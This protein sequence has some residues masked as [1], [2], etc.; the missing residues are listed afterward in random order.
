MKYTCQPA[1]FPI[2]TNHHG[3]K[4]AAPLWRFASPAEYNL[5]TPMHVEVILSN[6]EV[7]TRSGG[8]NGFAKV[9]LGHLW[10]FLRLQIGTPRRN[11]GVLV[12]M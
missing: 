5:A 7:F 11:Y 9:C 1:D 10:K 4:R 3:Q 12:S 8:P 2:W 6:S